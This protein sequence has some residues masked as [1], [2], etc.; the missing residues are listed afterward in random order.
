MKSKS[1]KA[2]GQASAIPEN[3]QPDSIS[4]GAK[5]VSGFGKYHTNNPNAK[6]PKPYVGLDLA[7]LRAL[8]DNPQEVHKDHAQW[9]IPSTLMSRDKDEQLKDG[10]FVMLWSEFDEDPQSIEKVHGVMQ[11]EIVGPADFEVYHSR[12]ATAERP[13]SHISIPLCKPLSGGDWLLAQEVLNDSLEAAG[14]KPDRSCE[15][16]SQICYLPNRG[17]LYETLKERTGVLFDPLAQWAGLIEKKRTELAAQAQKDREQREAAA[18]RRQAQQEARSTI[19]GRNLVAT[20]ND[21]YAV[22]EILIQ[23]GYDQRGDS[24][25]HPASESGSY[26]AGVKNGRV[27]ALSTADPLHTGAGAHDSFSAFTV[28]MHEGNTDAALTDAGDNW[29]KI[30][31]ESWNKVSRREFKKAEAEKAA[32]SAADDFDDET[33]NSEGEAKP[34]PVHP[35]AQFVD[36]SSAPMAPRWVIPG[37]IGHGVAVIAG[38]HGVGKTTALLP[39]A[40]VA[41]G[42]HEF[43]NELAPK[44]W[45]HVVYVVE[46]VE[47]A[48]RIIAGVVG[49]LD[50]GL[51]IDL[52]RER[53][54]IVAA[55]RL[56][57]LTVA[58]V[59][60]IYAKLFTRQVGAVEILP[61]VVLDTKAA[62]LDLENENDNAEASKAMSALKQGFADLPVWLVGHIA[63]ENMGRADVAALSSR[64]AGAFE[65]DANQ[66]LYVIKDEKADPDKRYLVRGKTRFEAKWSELEISTHKRDVVAVDEYGDK[67]LTALRWGISAPPT[68]SRMQAK[69]QAAEVSKLE[70]DAELRSEVMEA[71]TSAWTSGNPLNRERLKAKVKRKASEVLSCVGALLSEQ[72]L[73]EI[74]VPRKERIHPKQDSF[75]ICLTTA[76]HDAVLFL[77]SG[78]PPEKAVIPESWKKPVSSI[79]DEKQETAAATTH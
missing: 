8:V 52:V 10:Q 43:G 75:L 15:S 31:S 71:I 53:F 25:R 9:F 19:G 29:L 72:W 57:P 4:S 78:V 18:E 41:A 35:L 14:L 26:S 11:F 46:D 13:K 69:E 37:F 42:L 70:A 36:Y 23:A 45:R 21:E 32:A 24:F 17:A 65:A 74:E 76:E 60:P 28:L 56:D 47:Q 3:S 48:R 16:V 68:T 59:G 6:N 62:V 12:S 2:D 73:Y 40:M 44:H 64:G 1:R 63:K 33:G 22:Q 79:P 58:K 39:L 50:L 27:N 66:V 7:G 34:K 30:G 54:H 20:F 55:K 51:N 38:G 77:N 61:L 67:E 49:Q 5:M